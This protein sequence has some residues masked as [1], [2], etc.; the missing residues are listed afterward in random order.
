M[1]VLQVEHRVFFAGLFRLGNIELQVGVGGAHQEEKAGDVGPDLVHQ[2]VERD[3][4][5]LA[6]THLEGFSLLHNRYELVYHHVDFR[7]VVSQRL[8]S[9]EHV[10]IGVDM[11]GPEDVD[12]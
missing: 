2:L 1:C 5:G 3:E 8:E 6:G 11:V 9:R 7:G 12:A 10:G 4:I